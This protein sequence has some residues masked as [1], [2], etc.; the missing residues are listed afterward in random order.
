MARHDFTLSPAVHPSANRACPPAGSTVPKLGP[1][2]LEAIKS[3][4]SRRVLNA[5]ANILDRITKLAAIATVYRR[6][7][8][9]LLARFS[10]PDVVDIPAEQFAAACEFLEATPVAM[11]A[12]L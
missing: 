2:Q 6:L 11:G 12:K 3:I 1:V 8:A 10:V 7:G 5:V 9:D 4:M